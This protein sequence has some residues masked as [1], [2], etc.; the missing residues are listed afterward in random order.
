MKLRYVY[1]ALVLFL[2]S[3]KGANDN[4]IVGKS[5]EARA[6]VLILSIDGAECEL[7]PL[8]SSDCFDY[9]ATAYGEKAN[10]LVYPLSS[11]ATLGVVSISPEKVTLGATQELSVRI[12]AENGISYRDYKVHLKKY[13][14][15]SQMVKV[16][17]PLCGID[18]PLG[19]DDK[20]GGRQTNNKASAKID[21]SFEIGKHEVTWKLW[22]EVYDWAVQHDYH[23]LKEGFKGGKDGEA[24]G[25]PSA[26]NLDGSDYQPVTRI[27]TADMMVWCNAYSEMLKLP[28]VY[29]YKGNPY[30]DARLKEEISGHNV[31]AYGVLEVKNEVGY[32]LP[33]SDEWEVAA[34]WQ[35]NIK[36][37]NAVKI[38]K[39]GIYFYF[40][41]GDSCSGGT[42]HVWKDNYMNSLDTPSEND[43]VWDL[44]REQADTYCVYNEYCNKG[45]GYLKTGV[46]STKEVGTK[47]A[48]YL[49]IYD[50]SGNVAE[51]CL[52]YKTMQG[53]KFNLDVFKGG[54]WDSYPG[55]MRIGYEDY[56]RNYASNNHGFRL[57]RT[58][59]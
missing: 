1:L 40:T 38:D 51:R 46:V 8:F 11:K 15:Y 58:S 53:T 7:S 55:L 35:G 28:H 30:K 54:S 14:K 52:E 47:K 32:R 41:K 50:M 44:I 10:L 23:F 3:C 2:F 29:Y 13:T 49:S 42:F 5:S 12:T 37:D 17:I 9:E 19:I 27:S 18:V 33:T 36:T 25:L 59:R 26:P 24:Y 56:A 21:I 20:G 48:N 34:R 57:A 4:G 45:L 39:D 6:S 22:K 43:P 31:W 16:P